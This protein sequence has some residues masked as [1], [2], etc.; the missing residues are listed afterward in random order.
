MSFLKRFWPVLLLVAVGALVWFKRNKY[1]IT[2]PTDEIKIS[3]DQRKP[4]TPTTQSVDK[5]KETP[6][7]KVQS[8]SAFW[9]GIL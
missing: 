5:S 1:S 7:L 4:P 9:A 2:I 3:Y 6:A 8:S